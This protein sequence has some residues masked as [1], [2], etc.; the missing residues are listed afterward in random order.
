LDSIA[1]YIYGNDHPPPHVHAVSAE[2]LASIR[3]SDG[4]VTNGKMPSKQL[5][6]VT[7]WI[8]QNRDML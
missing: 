1:I 5:R 3:I 2:Y 4:K 6:K 7:R 8:E